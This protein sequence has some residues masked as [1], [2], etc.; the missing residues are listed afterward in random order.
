MKAE[1]Y[2]K[3]LCKDGEERGGGSSAKDIYG[4]YLVTLELVTLIQNNEGKSLKA[5]LFL[6]TVGKPFPINI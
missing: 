5:T 2:L 3:S 1:R 4:G 6:K